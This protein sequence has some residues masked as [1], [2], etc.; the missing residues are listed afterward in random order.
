MVEKNNRFL[1]KW[2]LSTNDFV[3]E[4]CLFHLI[5]FA[6]CVITLTILK[7]KKKMSLLQK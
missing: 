1:H 3:V 4:F 6:C 5:L 2:K 7:E